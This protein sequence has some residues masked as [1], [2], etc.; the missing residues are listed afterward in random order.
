MCRGVR[1]GLFVVLV[2]CAALWACDDDGDAR[3]RD[4][5]A[6]T[7][8]DQSPADGD[9]Q[10]PEIVEDVPSD[11]GDTQRDG[12]VDASDDTDTADVVE[13]L[14]PLETR[15]PA[16]APTDPLAGSAIES[17]AVFEEERC[18]GTQRYRCAVYDTNV[19]EFVQPD[20]LLERVLMFDR[21][22]DLYHQPM[23]QTAE[24]GF[25]GETLPG[26]PES[27]WGAPEHFATYYGLG[28]AA[29]WNG[30]AL[31]SAAMRYLA[32]GTDADYERM[33][34][35]VRDIVMQ[36]DVTGVP[37]YLARYH[38]VVVDDAAPRDP[39]LVLHRTSETFDHTV[40][41]IENPAAL[42]A[43]PAAYHGTYTAPDGSTW[44]AEPRWKGHPS[45]D[46]YSG[47]RA[48][49]TF[50]HSL[51][52]DPA[53]ADRIEHHLT[54][55]L[56]RLQRIE[57][58][59]L[60]ANPEL[61]ES[62]NAYFAGVQPQL[63]PD[64]IDFASLER[65]VMYVHRQV[66]D[67]NAG[68]LSNDCPDTVQLEPWRVIDARSNGFLTDTLALVADLQSGASENARAIDH[69]YVPSVR[70]ADAM[71]LMHLAAQAYHLTGD[72]QYR[73][74][75]FEELIGELDAVRVAHTAGAFNLPEFC[76]KFYGHH[77]G[78]TPAWA[79]IE[80]LEPG[81]ALRDEMERVFEVEL[82]QKEMR[83]HDNAK[84]NLMYAGALSP[85]V[86]SAREAAIATALAK[87]DELGGNG[88]LL[89]DPRRAYTVDRTSLIE[90][91]LASGNALRCPTEAERAACED[92][93]SV[94][95]VT[96]PGAPLTFEC[97]GAVGECPMENG[98]CA[99][100]MSRDALP[101]PVRRYEDFAWQRTP[102]IIGAEHHPEGN[103]QSP[104]LDLTEEFWL[105]RHYGFTE[106]GLGQVLAW[107]EVGTC[108]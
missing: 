59:N 7:S 61:L 41:R 3:E 73:R 9:T 57:I 98:R 95:G 35:K 94:L 46:Q 26:T 5:I 90:D 91:L 29:I 69:F 106:T 19:G 92:G 23:G 99:L 53:L 54:C 25:V 75:L 60:Q 97:T 50:V 93:I 37:G 88:G 13:P 40:R 100:A 17:C 104:G 79:F 34:R 30:A 27:Q 81:S 11:D 24:R 47:P 63:D 49:F 20:P 21:W 14:P 22:Y 39:S 107:Q 8:A 85:S 10:Q 32:T 70:G 6:D 28:D 45:I 72:E 16:A 1:S 36:F 67:A 84:F 77:I 66:N 4:V 87:L 76:R 51:L 12:E 68:V 83:T 82:W 18:S 43:L 2:A 86:A 38:F 48:A 52:R 44:S 71:H 64:D 96:V 108:E 15:D 33:E 105:A 65:I 42:D 89:L 56:K 31:L 74:F 78:F 80:L 58:I 101:M 62:L 55:Y 103:R 102:F